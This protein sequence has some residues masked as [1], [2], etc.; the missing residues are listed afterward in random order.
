[1]RRLV[2]I[3]AYPG[4]EPLDVVG[5]AEVF[6]CAARIGPGAYRTEVVAEPSSRCELRVGGA[7]AIAF[8][9][10]PGERY[11]NRH[12]LEAIERPRRLLFDRLARALEA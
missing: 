12:V 4:I 3:L 1:M 6:S 7:W 11:R 5:P 2:A 10:S 8:G 9:L